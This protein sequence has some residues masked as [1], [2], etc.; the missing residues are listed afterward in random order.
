ML[1]QPIHR[2]QGF[3]LGVLN[4][5]RVDVHR[6]PDLGSWLPSRGWLAGRMSGRWMGRRR[7]MATSDQAHVAR[8]KVGKGAGDREARA[9]DHVAP[10]GPDY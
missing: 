1:E 9:D 7:G 10:V 5:V 3:P 2:G 8:R 6:H 4:D